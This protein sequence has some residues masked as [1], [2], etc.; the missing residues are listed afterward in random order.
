MSSS[1]SSSSMRLSQ[2]SGTDFT[3]YSRRYTA[4]WLASLVTTFLIF[5]G[6]SEIL[7]RFQVE[8]NDL[9]LK[10]ASL[11]TASRTANAVFGDSHASLGFTGQAHF[12]NLAFPG[13]NL[14]TIASKVDYY[15]SNKSPGYVIFQ[16]GPHQF[17][18]RRNSEVGLDYRNADWKPGLLRTLSS[19][20]RPR[21]L[22]FWQVYLRGDGFQVNRRLEPDGAQIIGSNL[23]EMSVN[24]R[25]AQ[26]E[27]TVRDQIPPVIPSEAKAARLA[28]TALRA[29]VQQGAQI[30]LVTFPVSPDQAELSVKYPEVLATRRYIDQLAN[31]LG[32]Q[33]MDYW[34]ALRNFSQFTNSD[35]LNASGAA[36]LAARAVADCGFSEPKG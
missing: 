12:I 14:Q 5:L 32:L 35:H 36:G 1:I 6:A 16:L 21:I 2:E 33:R 8:P 34:S 20:Y 23:V 10:H 18:E 3:G 17:S 29:L 19:W 11:M 30:C 27:R 7:V 9:L 31:D 24:D 15:F 28:E 4:V 22:D 13:E 26:A 25:R